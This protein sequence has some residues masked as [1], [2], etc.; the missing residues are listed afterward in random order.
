MPSG[1][2]VGSGNRG[3]ISSARRAEIFSLRKDAK[4]ICHA[5]GR[6]TGGEKHH[7]KTRFKTKGAAGTRASTDRQKQCQN[8]HFLDV[9]S[10]QFIF[11]MC[12]I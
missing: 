11:D 1:G 4:Y 10:Y 7:V 9:F 6:T 12:E 3:F 8:R 5:W 2:K